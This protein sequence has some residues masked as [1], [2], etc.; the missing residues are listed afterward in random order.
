MEFERAVI[1]TLETGLGNCG[2][3]EGYLEGGSRG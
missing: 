3:G 1:L 2:R